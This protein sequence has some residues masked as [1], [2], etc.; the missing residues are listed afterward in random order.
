MT[1]Q[2]AGVAWLIMAEY[3]KCCPN[4][5][6]KSKHLHEGLNIVEIMTQTGKEEKREFF[7]L[8]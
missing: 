8:L 3:E 6:T 2:C 4:E 1:S 5:G 7:F